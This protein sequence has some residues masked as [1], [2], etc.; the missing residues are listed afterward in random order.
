MKTIL[1]AEDSQTLGYILSE[2]L[3]MHDFQV[4][5]AKDGK[6]GLECFQKNAIDLCILDVMM[7]EQDGFTLAKNIKAMNRAT[8]IIFLTAKSL[9]TDKLKGFRLG[10]DDYIV[11]PIDEE[12][13]V[14]R[15]QAVLNRTQ[16]QDSATTKE[17][18]H[19]GQYVFD[20]DTQV[21]AWNN[22]QQK[23]SQREAEVLKMLCV[24]KNQVMKRDIALKQIWGDNDYFTR[25]SMD[26]FISKLRKYLQHDSTVKITNI[27]GKGFI[28]SD[29]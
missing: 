19:I 26:V 10:A 3:E 17:T 29:G 5:W 4:I 25:R 7:P 18:Y 13:L 15:V 27:H 6:E 12:L 1:L 23:L 21:L 22:Q 16:A 20:Y 8:P 9:K 2:Y 11:K 14:A 24:N 28:L